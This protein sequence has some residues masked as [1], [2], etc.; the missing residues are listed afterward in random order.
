M[1]LSLSR[2]CTFTC[3]LRVPPCL[4]Q[5]SFVFRPNKTPLPHRAQYIV[6]QGEAG[7]TFY[8]IVKGTV[9]VLETSIDPETGKRRYTNSI[10]FSFC[11]LFW[12]RSVASV[13]CS[14][15]GVSDLSHVVHLGQMR[16]SFRER[17]TL[18]PFKSSASRLERAI[19]SCSAV[20][21]S[22]PRPG[23]DEQI[24]LVF[25]SRLA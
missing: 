1:H 15:R 14:I 22:A 10:S 18:N 23:K 2:W 24:N 12:F 8:M 7:E 11:F 5:P 25:H 13:F 19:V 17:R 3:G 16:R 21:F 6:R 20:S 9:D 4:A